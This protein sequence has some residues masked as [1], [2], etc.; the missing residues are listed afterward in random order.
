[1]NDAHYFGQRVF[2]MYQDWL[3]LVPF[4]KS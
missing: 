2:D 1:M 3:N 4:N